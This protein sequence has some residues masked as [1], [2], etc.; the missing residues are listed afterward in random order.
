MDN[1]NPSTLEAVKVCVAALEDKKAE[2]IRVFNLKGQ[3]SITDVV[4]IAT[5]NS[6][7]H[8]RALSNTIE[9]VV[10]DQ[11]FS[12]AGV[13]YQPQSGWL[14]VDAYSIMLHLMLPDKREYYRLEDMWR[15]AQEIDLK[16]LR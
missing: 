6:E 15:H 14:V 3:S 1:L 2:A 9:G 10:K 13:D 11:A 5:G 4:I 8:L 16:D 7:P 12:M